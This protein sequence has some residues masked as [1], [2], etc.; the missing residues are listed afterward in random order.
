[1]EDGDFAE[2]FVNVGR[3]EGA[4]AGDFQRILTERAGLD[5]AAVQRIRVRERNA[6]VSVRR[7]ELE[8][9]LAALTGATI[10]GKI[11]AAEPARERGAEPLTDT[12]PHDAPPPARGEPPAQPAAQPAPRPVAS[13]GAEHD[14]RGAHEPS[15]TPT[16]PLAV[17][18]RDTRAALVPPEALP[19]DTT[20]E[21]A[22]GPA[23]ERPAADGDAP[24]KT[25]AEPSS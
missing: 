24:V 4:R 2:I 5:R 19:A 12:A 3:R 8:Q 9:A 13:D 10:A 25:H 15:Y 23:T 16:I 14:A 20:N 6:F 22:E 7:G 18:R 11:A 17:V 1:M 21:P